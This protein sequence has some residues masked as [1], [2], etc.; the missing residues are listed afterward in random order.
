[1]S[2]PKTNYNGSVF[3]SRVLAGALRLDG[4]QPPKCSNCGEELLPTRKTKVV[5]QYLYWQKP[6]GSAFTMDE[7]YLPHACMKCGNV[8][9]FLK[10]R[11]RVIQEYSELS[12]D[13][14]KAMRE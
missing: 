2:L 4:D 10:N 3:H 13:E 11:E 6:W 7:V 1:M 9:F 8:Q 12:E 5:H 14:R